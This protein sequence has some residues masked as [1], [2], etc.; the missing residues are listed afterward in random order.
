MAG[1]TRLRSQAELAH[2]AR[3]S[4]V[5]LVEAQQLVAEAGGGEPPALAQLSPRGRAPPRCEG[6]PAR[7]LRLPRGPMRPLCGRPSR[8]A[9]RRRA[10]P[11][12]SPAAL[13][14]GSPASGDGTRRRR[15]RW[16][17]SSAR[18]LR[19]PPARRSTAPAERRAARRRSRPSMKPENQPCWA[20]SVLP[21]ESRGGT[22]VR[23]RAISSASSVYPNP[24]GQGERIGGD[25][26]RAAHVPGLDV[27][28]EGAAQA[29]DRGLQLVWWRASPAGRGR[30]RRA[31][32]RPR[33]RS[34]RS[35]FRGERALEVG[36][37]LLGGVRRE[38]GL[39]GERGVADEL[40]RTRG[41]TS[42]SP[43]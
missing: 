23:P 25:G 4:P 38:R 36:E 7:A 10:V 28:V 16:R 24:Q 2:L 30:G 12:R 43:K 20:S 31:A 27:V 34:P 39:A 41:L 18:G 17:A 8:C 32:L 9:G 42:A 15:P 21:R 29:G 11:A 3:G 40:V 35:P 14:S 37:R 13:S 5:A 19:R 6:A 1:I 33:R 26:D 22:R